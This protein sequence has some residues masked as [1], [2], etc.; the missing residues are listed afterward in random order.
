MSAGSA[1]RLV[2]D[3]GQPTN[4]SPVVP[5]R[6]PKAKFRVQYVQFADGS[7]WGDELAAQ[8]ALAARSAIF[9]MLVR[10]QSEGNDRHFLALLKE[11]IKPDEA[12]QFFDSFRQ[13]SKD[14]GMTVVRRNV[15]ASLRVASAH[16]SAM[17]QVQAK[18]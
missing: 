14:E 15:A 11:K 6:E 12:N 7:I 18:R 2:S 1:I 17:R 4:L 16:V 10:L 9:G 13:A 3:E 8:D 5:A